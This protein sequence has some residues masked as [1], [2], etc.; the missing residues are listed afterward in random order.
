MAEKYLDSPR[1]FVQSG[2]DTFRQ[3]GNQFRE[4]T[5][6]ALDGFN[7]IQPTPISFEVPVDLQVDYGTFARPTAPTRP[8]LQ[9]IAVTLPTAPDLADVEVPTIDAAP[10]EPVFSL[11]YSKPAA[12]NTPMPTR[13]DTPPVSL[14]AI[15]MPDAP[16][17]PDIE[18]PDL[19]DLNLPAVPDLTVPEFEGVRPELDFE[20][21][22][23]SFTFAP[24][25]YDDA[26][27]QTI[28]SRLS[29]M[30]ITGLGLPPDVEAAIFDRARGREDVLTLQQQQEF[31]DDLAARGLRQ[32]AG[33]LQRGRERIAAEARQRASGANRDLSI[34]V[35]QQNVEAIRWALSQAIALEVSLIQANTANNELALRGA[36]AEQQV[37]IDLFNG[38]VALHNAQVEMFKAD[39]SVVESKIRAESLII[40][41]YKAQIDAEKAK[42]DINET[43]VRALAE[44]LRARGVLIDLYRANVEAARVKGEHNTQLLEQDRLRLQTFGTEVD[45]WAKQ[46]DGYRISVDAELG[47]LRAQEVLGNVYGRR[48]ETW[49]TK[50]RAYFDRGRFQIEAQVQQLEKYRAALQGALIDSQ[51]QTAT[52]EAKLRAY[53]TDGS[54]YGIQA[55]VSGLEGEFHDRQGRMRIEAAG[56]RV[57][58]LQ[59]SAELTANYALKVID[60]Q[61]EVL[62]AKANVVAQMAASTASGMN[63][64]ASYSG[65]IGVSGSYGTSF[66][67][68]GDT[69]D[70]NPPAFLIPGF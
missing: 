8:V 13:P 49:A 22:T 64:G 59:R 54:I 27:V 23:R 66:S 55:Q 7:F 43:L 15:D 50:N 51:T 24:N 2:W 45:A 28:R 35:A 56:L 9:D 62:K 11:A 32:P 46:Q 61:I 36:I 3:L 68:S 19:Y 44:R 37:A 20:A 65:S 10:E 67:Y 5:F 18:D 6:Q 4:Y 41:R 53:Q 39:A 47:N 57:Q 14:V 33:L 52:Q 38:R 21:P 58:T 16:A 25:Q 48:V 17:L 63:F 1:D 40:D 30:A 60:Q 29:S 42:G 31:A 26:V 34:A 69:D 12:P 70:A